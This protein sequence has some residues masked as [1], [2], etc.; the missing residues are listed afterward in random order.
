MTKKSA[1]GKTMNLVVW[2]GPLL[3]LGFSLII[4]TSFLMSSTPMVGPFTPA[5]THISPQLICG[6][7]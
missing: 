1:T 3:G 7:V 2:R 5:M 4:Y 6:M